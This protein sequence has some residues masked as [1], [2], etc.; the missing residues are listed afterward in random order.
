VLDHR[1]VA[2]LKADV[3]KPLRPRLVRSERSILCPRRE[4]EID[5]IGAQAPSLGADKR[6]AVLIGK[7][8]SYELDAATRSDHLGLDLQPADRNRAQ[9]L[10]G[11]PPNLRGQTLAAAHPAL[12]EAF[13]LAADQR[14]G[15]ARVL[16]VR[17]PGPLG[18]LGGHVEVA[19][20]LVE[21]LRHGAAS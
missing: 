18:Q 19:V 12:A 17:I 15:G 3:R 9:D 2:G 14:G 8:R 20:R 7:R 21:G 4:L 10:V 6:L 13:E 11:H 5:L 16:G 1:V